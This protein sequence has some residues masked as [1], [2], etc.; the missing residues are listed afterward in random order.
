[1]Q[2]CKKKKERRQKYMKIRDTN[3]FDLIVS[4][5]TQTDIGNKKIIYS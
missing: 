5:D 2:L 1:M 3:A 4:R